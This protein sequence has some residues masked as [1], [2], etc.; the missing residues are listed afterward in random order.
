M[1]SGG[2]GFGLAGL[3]WRALLR[4]HCVCSSTLAVQRSVHLLHLLRSSRG[5]PLSAE[6]FGSPLLSLRLRSSDSLAALSAGR[7][8]MAMVPW[9]HERLSAPEPWFAR[10]LPGHKTQH[11]LRRLP[12]VV[13]VTLFSA[14]GDGATPLR[15]VPVGDGEQRALLLLRGSYA[16]KELCLRRSRGLAKRSYPAQNGNHNGVLLRSSLCR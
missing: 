12:A 16:T 10:C 14:V 15:S 3:G 11:A 4:R 9:C 2:E 5:S 1:R 7:G 8:A 13:H 6:L